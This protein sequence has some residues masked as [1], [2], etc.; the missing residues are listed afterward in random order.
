MSWKSG[1]LALAKRIIDTGMDFWAWV[2]KWDEL[3]IE[4]QHCPFYFFKSKTHRH[5]LHTLLLWATSQCS[6]AHMKRSRG[7]NVSLGDCLCLCVASLI[8]WLKLVQAVIPPV[9][10]PDSWGWRDK[11][12]SLSAGEG[13][14]LLLLSAFISKTGWTLAWTMAS[15]NGNI[16]TRLQSDKP[17]AKW[18][19]FEFKSG[20][21]TDG[22]IK[23]QK[24]TEVNNNGNESV[25]FRLAVNY[26]RYRNS[27][28]KA[29]TAYFLKHGMN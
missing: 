17:A 15:V 18:T 6:G 21:M 2:R 16:E 14:I 24:E 23:G 29:I 19:G 12:L 25:W 10:Q 9:A 8:N 28:A 22:R 5:S 27:N 20:K 7:V 4:T 3:Q 11:P 13:A 1:S 26:F